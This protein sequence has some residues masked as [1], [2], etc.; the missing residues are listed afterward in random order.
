MNK[1]IIFLVFS[2]FVSLA[3]SACTNG[4]GGCKTCDGTACEKCL[5]GYHSPVAAGTCT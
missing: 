3:F 1:I 2:S 5:A 4:E